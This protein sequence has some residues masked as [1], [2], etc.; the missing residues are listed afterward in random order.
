MKIEFCRGKRKIRFAAGYPGASREVFTILITLEPS[1]TI[2]TAWEGSVEPGDWSTA[3]SE[4]Q[5]EPKDMIFDALR[6]LLPSVQFKKRKKTHR[7][8]LL[9]VK[10]QVLA[11]NFTKKNTPPWVFFIFLNCTNG[12]KWRNGPHI[13]YRAWGLNY[14]HLI[15]RRIQN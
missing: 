7:R 15:Q 14:P 11:C 9:L 13:I 3:D 5:S 10:L 12:T 1:T 4:P 2:P 6:D 8:V